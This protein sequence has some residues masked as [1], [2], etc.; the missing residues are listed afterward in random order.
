MHVLCYALV[1]RCVCVN[2]GAG[3]IGWQPIKTHLRRASLTPGL[4][5]LKFCCRHFKILNKFMAILKF[6]IT[7]DPYFHFELGLTNHIAS[8]EHK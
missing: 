5:L 6:F 7:K 1:R 8:P 4:M 3:V 2:V